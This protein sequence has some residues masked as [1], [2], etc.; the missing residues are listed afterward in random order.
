MD[1]LVGI[2]KDAIQKFCQQRSKAK[3][4][5]IEWKFTLPQWW[6]FW[7]DHW[8]NRGIYHDSFV[9]ARF[10]DEGPYSPD[11]VRIITAS[12]NIREYYSNKN[13]EK[14]RDFFRQ[15]ALLTLACKEMRLTYRIART[16]LNGPVDE[17]TTKYAI[18]LTKWV[19]LWKEQEQK[20][21]NFTE[22]KQFKRELNLAFMFIAF[23]AM[24]ENG[25]E[26][27]EFKSI[28]GDYREAMEN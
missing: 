15:N 12:E 8:H 27:E 23:E 16:A 10:G 9:M 26:S 6:D 4:R 22:T 1:E 13:I 3:K 21:M 28:I 5:N 19:K 14:T 24:N 7:K 2:P 11:N 20:R 18:M 25:M 17:V